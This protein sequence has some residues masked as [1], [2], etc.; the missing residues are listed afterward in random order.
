[1]RTRNGEKEHP[2]DDEERFNQVSKI[3]T[4]YQIDEH[5]IMAKKFS[6]PLRRTARK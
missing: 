2:F 3:K 6:L 4:P 5:L 1:M